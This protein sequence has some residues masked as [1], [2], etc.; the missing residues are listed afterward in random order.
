MELDTVVE[1]KC[2]H[3][4]KAYAASG[5]MFIRIGVVFPFGIQNGYSRGQYIIGDMMVADDEIN[6][7]LLGVCDFFDGFD[8]AVQYNN[9][10]YTTLCGI[11]Y[12]LD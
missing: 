2:L 10:T 1:G 8:T 9:Q 4:L 3:E 6:A 5:Q 11:V 12:S 7:F